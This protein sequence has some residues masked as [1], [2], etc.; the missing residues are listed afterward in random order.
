MTED[1]IVTQFGSVIDAVKFRQFLVDTNPKFEPYLDQLTP[2]LLNLLRTCPSEFDPSS[3]PESGSVT[4]DWFMDSVSD[5]VFNILVPDDA[6]SAD[7]TDMDEDIIDAEFIIADV[8]DLVSGN[9]ITV[10][11]MAINLMS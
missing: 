11:R 5:V 8:L 9:D 2:K 4:Y 6:K 10:L 7:D 3:K 1:K